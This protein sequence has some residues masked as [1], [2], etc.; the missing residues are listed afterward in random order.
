MFG[1]KLKKKINKPKHYSSKFNIAHLPGKD[2]RERE[3]HHVKMVLS[4][5]LE[6]HL[7]WKGLAQQDLVPS[8]ANEAAPEGQAGV[9]SLWGNYTPPIS[10]DGCSGSTEC[11]AAPLRLKAESLA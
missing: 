7:G 1:A 6:R 3:K 4:S 10:S 11:K 2:L 8:D 5:D 9:R